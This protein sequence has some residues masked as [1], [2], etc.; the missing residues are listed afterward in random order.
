[1][2]KTGKF[3]MY[4]QLE[5]QANGS[6]DIEAFVFREGEVV[7]ANQTEGKTVI[8]TAAEPNYAYEM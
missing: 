3:E 5:D 4:G 6:A 1:M 2:I 8:R 7:P